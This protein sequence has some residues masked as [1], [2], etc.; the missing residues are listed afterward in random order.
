[1][2]K[3]LVP[4]A[5]IFMII[6]FLLLSKSQ[7]KEAGFLSES[8]ASYSEKDDTISAPSRPAAPWLVA[9]GIGIGVAQTDPFGTFNRSLGPLLG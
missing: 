4:A 8:E 9:G 3:P 7:L 2:H 6:V 1:M 5:L